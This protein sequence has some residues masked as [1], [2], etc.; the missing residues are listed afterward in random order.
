MKS[1]N[2]IEYYGDNWGLPIIAQDKKDGS[3]LRFE[4][5]QKRGFYKFGTRNMVIDNNH[6]TFGFAIDLFLNK[7]NEKLSSIFK[8]KRYRNSLSFVCYAELYGK[9]SA[10]G[11]HDFLN[12]KF[13]V[14][15]FDISEYKKEFIQPREFIKDFGSTGIPDIVYDGNLNKEFVEKV[16]NNYYN[17][18]EG[19]I[20]KGVIPNKKSHN[21]YYCKIKTNDWF[22]RLRQ[23][24]P[25]LYK[26][27]L[28]Q[29]KNLY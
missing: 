21:L 12:D 5:S 20:C 16:K 6:E 26:E 7:Y 27:E 11:Q 2:S 25:E 15:L 22:E 23:T 4:F 18:T 19:V 13:D 28:L 1:Y 9:N 14:L 24:K 29:S 17:L 3:N 10:F 8:N